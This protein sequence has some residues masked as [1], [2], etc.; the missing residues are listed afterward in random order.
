MS[1]KAIT[2]CTFAISRTVTS[3][4]NLASSDACYNSVLSALSSIL[5]FGSNLPANAASNATYALELLNEAS[6]S[7][8]SLRDDALSV[9]TAAVRVSTVVRYATDLYGS[10]LTPAITDVE[11]ELGSVFTSAT[12]SNPQ[13]QN[14]SYSQVAVTLTVFTAKAHPKAEGSV[15][16]NSLGVRIDVTSF[17]SASPSHYYLVLQNYQAAHYYNYPVYT[18]KLLCVVHNPKKKYKVAVTCPSGTRF[19]VS[20]PGT[21]VGYA[22]YSCPAVKS[23]AACSVWN[24]VTNKYEQ[25]SYCSVVNYTA[26]TTTCHCTSPTSAKSGRRQLASAQSAA[27]EL[28]G[29]TAVLANSFAST[30]ESASQLSAASVSRNYVRIYCI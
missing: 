25:P 10:T 5:S 2:A 1:T 13:G 23:E 6:R 22:N 8:R 12:V 30:L 14:S 9:T 19:N 28:A 16:P 3:H 21:L 4:V 18:S 24:S 11:K 17:D 15:V 29:S 20:C 7:S 26:W 27:L